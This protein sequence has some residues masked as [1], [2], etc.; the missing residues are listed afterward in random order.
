MVCCV[1]LCCDATYMYTRSALFGPLFSICTQPLG[2]MELNELERLWDQSDE[3]PV[4]MNQ[5]HTGSLN[6]N[7]DRTVPAQSVHMS[8]F[9]GSH[10]GTA[11]AHDNDHPHLAAAVSLATVAVDTTHTF[12]PTM[13]GK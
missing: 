9:Y 10:H 6:D 13:L 11:D 7:V 2:E 12:T 3:L 1:V 5:S 8:L 4:P